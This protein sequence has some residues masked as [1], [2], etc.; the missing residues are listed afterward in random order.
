MNIYL[1][2]MPLSGKS[3]IGRMLAKQLNKPFIDLDHKVE[4]EYSMF[5]DEI[6]KITVKRFLEPMRPKY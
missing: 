3:S 5:V 6:F 1:I 2:G 4:V